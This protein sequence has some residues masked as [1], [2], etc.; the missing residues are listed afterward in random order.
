MSREPV[1]TSRPSRRADG[2]QPCL[3]TSGRRADLE[4]LRAAAMLAVVGAHAVIPYASRQ[5]PGLPWCVAD[6]APAVA[7][8]PLFWWLVSWAMPA[9]FALAGYAGASVLARRGRRG[10]VHDRLRRIGRPF[11]L[12][13]P[14][15]LGPTFFI[16]VYG[17]LISGRAGP[18]QVLRLTFADPEIRANRYGP[19]HLWFLEYLLPMLGLLALAGPRAVAN[20]PVGRA[21]TLRALAWVVTPLLATTL[22]LHAGRLVHG[23]DPVFDMRNSFLIQPIRWL[24][25]ALFFAAGVLAYRH[26]ESHLFDTLRRWCRPLTALALL[27]FAVRFPLLARDLDAG[28]LS[29]VGLWAEAVSG[30]LVG[31]LSL[32]AALGLAGWWTQRHPEHP[33]LAW[34]ARA[35]FWVYLVHFPLVG[36]IQ[37]DLHHAPLPPWLKAATAFG[38]T[39]AL[40]LAGFRL[41]ERWGARPRD[42]VAAGVIGP[43]HGGRLAR[44]ETSVPPG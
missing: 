21:G 24:H 39:L 5:L 35:S 36:L 15:V 14:L 17:W 9:F 1:A 16:W 40:A 13:I 22:I 26:R 10:F 3:D 32:A 41:I 29:P 27:A 18:F 34:L 12:A 2:G 43:P 20:G 28:G 31:W 44:G 4:A 6:R 19:A 11:L 8:D 37:A 38:L 33:R 25:H 42:P 30:A 23:I 7:F